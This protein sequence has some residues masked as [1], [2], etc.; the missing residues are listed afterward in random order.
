M[1]V[2]TIGTCGMQ[3]MRN[4][5]RKSP[6]LVK[7]FVLIVIFVFDVKLTLNR[8]KVVKARIRFSHSPPTSLPSN[9]PTECT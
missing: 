2:R 3:R 9:G 6:L 4:S 7:R 5:F 8:L 1:D